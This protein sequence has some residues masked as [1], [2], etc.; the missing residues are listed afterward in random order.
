M[1]ERVHRRLVVLRVLLA[2]LLLTLSGRL[3]HLQ[4]QTAGDYTR[5]AAD[6][7]VREVAVPAARGEVLDAKGR[8]LVS[9][10]MAM[11]V[12]VDRANWRWWGLS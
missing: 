10:R 6:N 5:A 9:N 3:W 2:A 7:R 12:S 4:V 1:D 8:P 11:V